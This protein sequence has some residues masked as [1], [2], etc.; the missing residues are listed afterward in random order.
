[1]KN[2]IVAVLAV[3]GLAPLAPAANS[4][5]PPPREKWVEV[6]ETV[7]VRVP[8]VEY[9]EEPC[10]VK[11][12]RMVPREQ[13]V[14]VNAGKWVFEESEIQDC[15][16][17]VECETYTVNVTRYETRRETRVRRIPQVVCEEEEKTV[18]ARVPEMA[19]DPATG[20]MI[21][22]WREE[23]RT[24]TVPVRRTIMVEEPYIVE[25]K[26]PVQVP[27]VRTREVVREVP[28]VR[29]IRTPKYVCDVRKKTVKVM[30]PKVETQTVMRRRAVK[31]YRTIE[32]QVTKRIK[33]PVAPE[34]CQPDPC[35]STA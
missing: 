29:K 14:S 24:V 21:R 33:I 3:L 34:L 2:A 20:R 4:C 31:T 9:V 13:E 16:K 28:V 11:V 25:V 32:K 26:Y 23:C 6:C 10:E 5:A 30:E 12:N 19:C 18:V 15:K 17:V 1:M 22:T 35:R 27:V 7:R 8:V